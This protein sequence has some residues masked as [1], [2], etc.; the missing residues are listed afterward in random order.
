MRTRQESARPGCV[1][2]L[3]SRKRAVRSSKTAV[4]RLGL[5]ILLLPMVLATALSAQVGKPSA[6]T[7]PSLGSLNPPILS[8]PM[9]QLPAPP[10]LL[11]TLVVPR[12]TRAKKIPAKYDVSRI[13]AREV[14]KGLDFYSLERE[15]AMGREMALQVEWSSR[16]VGDPVIADYVNRLAQTLVRNSDSRVPL[17]VKVL[18]NDE[19]NAFAFPGGFFFVNT[20]LI[21]A[22]RSEAELTGVMAHEIAHV[23]ARHATKNATKAQLFNMLSVPLIFF[24]GPAG[25]IA[26]Q[27]MG[28]GVPLSMLKF[29]RNAEREAD[30][31]GL[32]YQYA[33]GYDPEEFVRFMERLRA[34]EKDEGGSFLAKAFQTHPMT[35]DRVRRAQ[36]E[37]LE[38]L[39]P[40]AS[41][42]VDT[43]DF[44]RV[45]ARLIAKQQEGRVESE[46]RPEPVLRRRNPATPPGEAKPGRQGQ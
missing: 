35:E 45:K 12:D 14:G 41:Y 1:L 42:I 24:G 34:R 21:L 22:A 32:Q 9:P 13:G 44:L 2:R 27:V 5:G 16:V 7:A 29:S 8:A 17:T 38:Y 43:S 33:S 18:D 25:Y 11:P 28:L 30:A 31:L 36:K 15:I 39:P 10:R 4:G 23:A 40:R 6:E 3:R 26:R 37:I 20:G 46:K 19:I